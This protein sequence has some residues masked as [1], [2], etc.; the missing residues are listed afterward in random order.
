[1]QV[2]FDLMPGRI[3]SG[4]STMTAIRGKQLTDARIAYY[5]RRGW[6]SAEVRDARAQLQKRKADRVA[7]R[8]GPFALVDGRMIY[9]PK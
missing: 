5:Q 8:E 6:Y 4:W 1:M 3:R 7:K 9:S 2:K